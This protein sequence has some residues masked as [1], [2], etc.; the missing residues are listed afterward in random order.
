MDEDPRAWFRRPCTTAQAV[1]CIRYSGFLCFFWGARCHCRVIVVMA[2]VFIVT[3]II[4]I[5]VTING[6]AA[7]VVDVVP[8]V[9]VVAAAVTVP[10]VLS[11]KRSEVN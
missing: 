4:A 7:A 1:A 9:A 6:A 3:G 5:I 11:F 10:I 8:I 2:V